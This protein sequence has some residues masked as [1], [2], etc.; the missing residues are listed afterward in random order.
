MPRQWHHREET[1]HN[2]GILSARSSCG[3][4]PPRLGSGVMAC[5]ARASRAS[6]CQRE[7]KWKAKDRRVRIAPEVARLSANPAR[8]QRESPASGTWSG[9]RACH[10]CPLGCL[11][12][13]NSRDVL[14]LW[15][16]F[17]DVW[18]PPGRSRKLASQ[19][20]V[21]PPDV[22]GRRSRK[23]ASQGSVLPPEVPA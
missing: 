16:Q 17:D 11:R 18:G 10:L 20:S 15:A 7:E 9:V 22:P 6:Q 8:S 1:R 13:H 21:L 4:S 5:S 19:G 14:A 23:L 12:E 3:A 2:N